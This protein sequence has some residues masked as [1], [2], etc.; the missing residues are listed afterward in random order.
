ML[1]SIYFEDWIAPHATEPCKVECIMYKLP[2]A[3]SVTAAL[4]SYFDSTDP[5]TEDAIIV[6][7]GLLTKAHSYWIPPADELG[8]YHKVVCQTRKPIR[9]FDGDDIV[10]QMLTSQSTTSEGAAWASYVSAG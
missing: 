1:R 10:V 5:L 2:G 3:T 6:R 9:M 8:T 7:R 4:S